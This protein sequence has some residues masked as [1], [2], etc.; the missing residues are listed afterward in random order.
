MLA[1]NIFNFRINMFWGMPCVRDNVDL[2]NEWNME[3]DV[4]EIVV[5]FNCNRSMCNVTESKLVF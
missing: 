1:E 5:C 3:L 4:F 2:Q